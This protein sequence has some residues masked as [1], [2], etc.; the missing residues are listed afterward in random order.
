[1]QGDCITAEKG[2]LTAI[3]FVQGSRSP[4]QPSGDH[5]VTKSPVMLMACSRR[6]YFRVVLRQ[7][8]SCLHLMHLRACH[9]RCRCRLQSS[10]MSALRQA[11][12]HSHKIKAP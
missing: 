8:S 4:S 11:A 6:D 2:A 12:P 3:V 10:M 7:E 1:M 9:S 5:L